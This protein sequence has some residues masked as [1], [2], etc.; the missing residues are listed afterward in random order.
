MQIFI[1]ETV[2]QTGSPSNEFVLRS[3]CEFQKVW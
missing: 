3:S 2:Y 1:S